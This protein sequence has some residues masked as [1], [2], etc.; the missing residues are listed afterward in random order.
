MSGASDRLRWAVE[1]LDPRPRDRVLELGC[2]HGVALTLIAERL[3]G[4]AVVGVD[5]SP[6]MTA[7]ARERNA[8]QIAAGRVSVITAAVEEID[9]DQRFDKVL[10][11]HFPPLLRGEPGTE[12]D[13]V[14]HHLADAGLVYGVAQPFSADQAPASGDAIAA[15]LRAHGFAVR[16]IT[17]EDVGAHRGVCVVAE[18][19]EAR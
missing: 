13:V 3:T 2:G 8:E 19:A 7:R 6:K 4:G 15:R 17:I 5:R 9:L 12:L 16:E 11:V 1:K 14:R 18:A 10:A